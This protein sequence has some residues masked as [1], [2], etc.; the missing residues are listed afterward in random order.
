LETS[1]LRIDIILVVVCWSK[2]LEDE[3]HRRMNYL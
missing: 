1:L 2:L 3:I